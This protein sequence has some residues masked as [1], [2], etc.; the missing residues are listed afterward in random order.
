MLCGNFGLDNTFLV[1]EVSFYRSIPY[2]R[3]RFRAIVKSGDSIVKCNRKL[4][5]I[6]AGDASWAFIA[7]MCLKNLEKNFY[8]FVAKINFSNSA[9]GFMFSLE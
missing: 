5:W 3:L 9:K 8:R 2:F 6:A 4:F 7:T 1:L